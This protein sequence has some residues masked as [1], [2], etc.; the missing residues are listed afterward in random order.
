MRASALAVVAVTAVLFSA[1]SPRTGVAAAAAVYPDPAR[2]AAIEKVIRSA[3][4]EGVFRQRDEALVRGGFAPTFVMQVYWDGEL[5]SATL[6]QWLAKMKLSGKPLAQTTEADVW[7]IEI[8][9]DA[10]VARI[11]LHI[12]G[13]QKYTDYFGLYDTA[14]GWRIVSKLFHGY[15]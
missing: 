5:S 14:E 15:R 10:A 8:C 11:D 4:L 9:G 2:A 3:Y 13:A 12:D 1:C 7:V 6:D